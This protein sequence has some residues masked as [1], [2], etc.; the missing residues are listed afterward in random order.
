[1]ADA[2]PDEILLAAAQARSEGRLYALATVVAASGS[3]PRA[4][5]A[6]LLVGPEGAMLGTVG[7]G[8]FEALVIEEA[9]ACLLERRTV[10][11]EYAL[12]EASPESFGAIC[13]GTATVFIEP[14][15]ARERIFVIGA[16]HVGLAIAKL[17][18]DCG[19]FAHVFDDRIDGADDPRTLETH[20][21]QIGWTAQDALVIVNRNPGLDRR[22]LATALRLEVRPGYVGMIGS[23]RKVRRVF[24]ELSE[25]GFAQAELA[26]VYAPIGLEIG[27]DAPMEIAVS[28]LA[29]VLQ[30][31]RGA[32]G[33]HKKQRP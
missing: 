18:R 33:G 27:S 14:V 28:V 3:C 32:K 11:R 19:L 4:P 29:E 25:E 30:V 15:G 17:A 12:H 8:K 1:M 7:G 23:E 16:G 6:R 2:A 24:V 21:Q 20:V 31:L 22:A 5:G 10:L 26:G 13:G 9:L